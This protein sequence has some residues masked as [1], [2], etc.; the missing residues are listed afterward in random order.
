MEAISLPGPSCPFL[1]APLAPVSPPHFMRTTNSSVTV[2]CISERRILLHHWQQAHFLENR[3]LP[4]GPVARLGTCC[5]HSVQ[6]LIYEATEPPRVASQPYSN[7]QMDPHMALRGQV[8]AGCFCRRD[9][10]QAQV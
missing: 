9:A 10:P 4:A 8:N 3:C 5:D 2:S 6:G 1:I 7:C